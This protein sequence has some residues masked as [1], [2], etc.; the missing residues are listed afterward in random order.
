MS[1]PTTRSTRPLRNRLL[2]AEKPHHGPFR[3]K[4]VWTTHSN[5]PVEFIEA[6][7][8]ERNAYEAWKIAA[9]MIRQSDEWFFLGVQNGNNWVV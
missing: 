8:L 4:A 9:H 7:I 2:L 1:K 5:N 3:Y 6:T